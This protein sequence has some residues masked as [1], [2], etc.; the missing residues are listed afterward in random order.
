[1]APASHRTP[2]QCARLA[3]ATE[4]KLNKRELEVLALTMALASLATMLAGLL[5]ENEANIVAGL[6]FGAMSALFIAKRRQL[7]AKP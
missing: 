7:N 2:G 4:L 5:R 1:M 3:G 6:F